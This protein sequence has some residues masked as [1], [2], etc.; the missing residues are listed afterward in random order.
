MA[1]AVGREVIALLRPGDLQARAAR[2]GRQVVEHLAGA[3]LPGVTAVRGRGLW[4]AIDLE[5]GFGDGPVARRA[6]DEVPVGGRQLCEELL[7][8]GVLAKDTHGST[9]RF[10]P[11]LTIG[12]DD[13]AHAVEAIEAAV[14]ALGR[15]SACR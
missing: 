10:A 1:A 5:P 9:V 11:P 8:R 6:A 14:R 7:R 15:P 3:R 2:L 12:E 4:W 13:L